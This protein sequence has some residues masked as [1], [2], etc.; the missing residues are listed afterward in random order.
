[1]RFWFITK[2]LTDNILYI[3]VVQISSM[4]R[5]SIDLMLLSCGLVAKVNKAI[6]GAGFHYIGLRADGST[7]FERKLTRAPY[8]QEFSLTPTL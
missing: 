7:M 5:V 8:P 3:R 4:S 6:S 1:V 2:F